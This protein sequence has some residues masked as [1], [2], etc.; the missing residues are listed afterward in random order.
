[1]D[2]AEAFASLMSPEGRVDPYPAYEQ[3]RAHGPV[4]QTGPGV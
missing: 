4:A 1:M 3:L 2:V